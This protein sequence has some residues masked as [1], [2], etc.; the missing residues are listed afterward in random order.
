MLDLGNTLG[1]RQWDTVLDSAL[2]HCFPPETQPH[3]LSQLHP[4]VSCC[5]RPAVFTRGL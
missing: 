3:Y 4:H 2:L 5:K 1:S